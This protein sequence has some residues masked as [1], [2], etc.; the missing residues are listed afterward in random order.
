MMNSNLDYITRFMTRSFEKSVDYYMLADKNYVIPKQKVHDY[1]SHV[2]S[3][4]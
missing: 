1:I 3:I 2:L 4:S